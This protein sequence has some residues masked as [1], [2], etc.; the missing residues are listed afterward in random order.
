MTLFAIPTRRGASPAT[1][2]GTLLLLAALAA[3]LSAASLQDDVSRRRRDYDN[4]RN[5]VGK[6]KKVPKLGDAQFAAAR[7]AMRASQYDEALR[8][9]TEYRDI[10]FT[11]RDL[12]LAEVPN[13]EKKSGGFKQMEIHVRKSLES[14]ADIISD[15]PVM[16]REA[17][18][19]IRNDL[20]RVNKLLIK[21]LFPRQ[22]GRTATGKQP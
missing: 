19:A 9:L 6:A 1:L 4:Q 13:P 2:A 12:L 5:A 7:A 21:D 15:A 17:F 16:Q 11:T 22:P 8:I 20:D 10:V 14:M 18:E 3:S